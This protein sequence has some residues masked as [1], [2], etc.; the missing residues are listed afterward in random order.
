MS[1][2][3]PIVL[4]V[5]KRPEHA[6]RTLEALQKNNLAPDSELYIFA[7][8]PK[9]AEDEEL[10]NKTRS[11]CKQFDGFKS[12]EMVEK[13]KNEGLATSIINGV[14]QLFKKHD[15]LIIMEDDLVS[16]PYF[17]NFMN[18][19]LTHFRNEKSVWHI[20]GWNYPIDSK[21]LN[22]SFLWRAMNCWG[23]GSWSDRWQHFRRDPQALMDQFS[24]SDIARFSCNG[25]FDFWE[26]VE[27]NAI[28]KL[29][30]WAI[31]WY[32]TIFKHDGLCLNPTQSY[33]SNVG[34]DG[35]G[36]HGGDQTGLYAQELSMKET[37]NLNVPIQED[38]LAL[39]RIQA[40]VKSLKP[41]ITQRIIGKFIRLIKRKG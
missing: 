31:F 29:N 41:G 39:Q 20:S 27:M 24:R 35:S 22:E 21:G 38:Q 18:Q 16:S 17:L 8:G 11:I 30:T 5:Y 2:F 4:F 40:Y 36:E 6:K 23:W 10:V 32:A 7:D 19:A 14:T 3:A 34:L 15:K 37:L 13:S 28:G 12:V 1:E 33:I 9:Q 25:T 26:Q